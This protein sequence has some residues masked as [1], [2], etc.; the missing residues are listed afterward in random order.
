VRDIAALE[1]EMKIQ[2]EKIHPPA[3]SIENSQIDA[4]VDIKDQKEK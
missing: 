1:K 4:E 3:Q 2:M